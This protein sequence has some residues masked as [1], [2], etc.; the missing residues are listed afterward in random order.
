MTDTDRAR[1]REILAEPEVARWWAL[2]ASTADASD[3][4]EVQFIDVFGVDDA[5]QLIVAVCHFNH[6]SAR[7]LKDALDGRDHLPE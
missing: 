1:L 7:L 3:D 4:E 6:A 2:S 5:A